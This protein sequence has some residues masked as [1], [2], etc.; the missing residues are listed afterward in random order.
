MGLYDMWKK[1]KLTEL[2][3]TNRLSI[4]E[5]LRWGRVANN[6]PS[7]LMLTAVLSSVLIL[8]FTIFMRMSS[9]ILDSPFSTFDLWM[10][11][12]LAVFSFIAFM[13]IAVFSSIYTQKIMQKYLEEK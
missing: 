5:E 2:D 11:Y 12:G 3:K 6:A 13:G 4:L 1:K 9:V 7:E 10:F 8:S